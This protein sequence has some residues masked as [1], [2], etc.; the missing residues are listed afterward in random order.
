MRREGRGALTR[1]LG[2]PM[3]P[4]VCLL[5][6]TFPDYPVRQADDCS[7]RAE[8]AGFVIGVQPID[9]L[10]D[11][12]TYFKTELTPNGFLPVYVVMQN[13][14]NGDSFLFDKTSV[15]YGGVDSSLSGPDV[16]QKVGTGRTIVMNGG[17]LVGLFVAGKISKAADEQLNILK[18]ELYS[19]TI[20]AGTSKHG[21]LYV[22]VP[23]D[24]PRGKVRLLVPIIKA[25]TGETSVMELVF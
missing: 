11:Q 12:R 19:C 7:V 5:A 21:F 15:T 18:R 6:V 13:G 24:G 20:S 4:A 17:G 1:I 14:T 23:K 9:D 16:R 22:P 10:K 3:M 2:L 8:K 25:S